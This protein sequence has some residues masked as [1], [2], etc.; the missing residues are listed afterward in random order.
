LQL[1]IG[2]KHT[3]AELNVGKVSSRLNFARIDVVVRGSGKQAAN[4]NRSDDAHAANPQNG[5]PNA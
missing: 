4:E 2:T 5:T 3:T 1:L